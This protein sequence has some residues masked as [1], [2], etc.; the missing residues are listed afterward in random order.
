ME[1]PRTDTLEN[2]IYCL[3]IKYILQETRGN[4]D[5]V[6]TNTLPRVDYFVPNP[7]IIVEIDESQHFSE[8]RRATF[9]KYPSN[10]K[11]GFD[12]EKWIGLCNK[13]NARDDFPHYRD[14]QRA[15]YDSLRCKS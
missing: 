11:L 5:F 10:L 1:F 2:S 13:I 6:R 7:G 3:I 9:N 15:W 12:K 4:R 8:I 14:G